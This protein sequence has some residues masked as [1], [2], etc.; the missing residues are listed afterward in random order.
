MAQVLIID[1]D[2]ALRQ[3]LTKHLER[4]GHAVR[5]A[6]EGAEGIA[7]LERQ[8]ADVVVVD[9]FMPQQGGLQTIG[10]MRQDWPGVKII[11][12]SGAS[13]GGPLDVR[14]HALALGA[15]QFI[16]KP[17]EAATLVEL[18]AQLIAEQER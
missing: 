4:A 1:D 2:I 6:S 12:M 3:A 8:P 9:I 15:H 14:E 13:R 17:F 7:S 5:Q 16:G 10:R 18:L 11:A